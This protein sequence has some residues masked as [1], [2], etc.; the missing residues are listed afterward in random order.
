MSI[1]AILYFQVQ[2]HGARARPNPLSTKPYQRAGDI[3]DFYERLAW[4]S[5][6]NGI[7]F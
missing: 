2:D 7:I 5:K 4:F 3:D 1:G 6:F